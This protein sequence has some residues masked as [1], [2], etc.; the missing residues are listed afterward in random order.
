MKRKLWI[1]ISILLFVA[2]YFG[3]TNYASNLSEKE[4]DK[5]IVTVSPF[6]EVDYKSVSVDLIGLDVR[7]S[8]VFIVS[9]LDTNYNVFIDEIIIRKIDSK[10]DI[11]T[12]MSV[13]IH[14]IDLKINDPVISADLEKYGYT[15]QL[16]VDLGIDY[17]YENGVLNVDD[18]FLSVDDVGELN[19]NFSIGNLPFNQQ[20]ILGFLAVY[21][22]ILLYKAQVVIDL[23][24]LADHLIEYGAKE[25]D[26]SIEDFR[27]KVLE[28]IE[29]ESE[30]NAN[31]F[32]G[33][34]AEIA[35]K[36]LTDREKLSISISPSE[37]YQQLGRILDIK[38]D[39]LN[40]LNF[41]IE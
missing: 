29:R 35:K 20:G 38:T 39:E 16:L 3:I 11:P 24:P 27:A 37:P 7:I 10:S 8:D 15:N 18:L 2:I 22:E 6:V 40:R 33:I 4:V 14:G 31:K 25:L 1:V 23:L 9:R 30:I 19:A 41:R 13:S 28:D 36:V 26:M 5:M 21:P 32:A 34:P 17:I 12:F